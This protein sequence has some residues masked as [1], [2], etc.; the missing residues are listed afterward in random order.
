M[1]SFIDARYHYD[2][3]LTSIDDPCALTTYDL[4]FPTGLLLADRFFAIAPRPSLVPSQ[5]AATAAAFCGRED[6]HHVRD[7]VHGANSISTRE[8]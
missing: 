2:G 7:F 8:L 6:H 5:A 1:G 3:N 4:S